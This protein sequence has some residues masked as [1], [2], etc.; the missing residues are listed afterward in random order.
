MN[1]AKDGTITYDETPIPDGDIPLNTAHQC[2]GRESMVAGMVAALLITVIGSPDPELA[3]DA[4]LRTVEVVANASEIPQARVEATLRDVFGPGSPPP[5]KVAS[6][7][8]LI[9]FA[10]L[11]RAGLMGG[12]QT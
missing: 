10:N 2:A 3:I 7:R 1:I 11:R 4:M 8:R 5:E 9:D 12:P 6:A